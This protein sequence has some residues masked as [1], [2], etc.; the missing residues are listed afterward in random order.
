MENLNELIKNKQ[1]NLYAVNT[2]PDGYESEGKK[3]RNSYI[4]I[5]NTYDKAP[6]TAIPTSRLIKS[7]NDFENVTPVIGVT[8]P[9]SGKTLMR[10]NVH[11]SNGL[12]TL[13]ISSTPTQRKLDIINKYIDTLHVEPLDNT[14]G[15]TFLFAD[16]DYVNDKISINEPDNPNVINELRSA[17]FAMAKTLETDLFQDEVNEFIEDFDKLTADEKEK[18]AQR[19]L[20][21]MN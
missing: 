16:Y 4:I 10:G 6:Q 13:I 7:I 2:A 11:F 15:E 1:F 20:D 5:A 12:Q 18:I 9:Y 19:L 3:F 21:D 14:I 17:L 8:E